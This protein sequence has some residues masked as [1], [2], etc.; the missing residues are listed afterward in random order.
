M[1]RRLQK[2]AQN[3][4]QQKGS[5]LI[6]KRLM[7]IGIIIFT[8]AIPSAIGPVFLGLVRDDIHAHSFVGDTGLQVITICGVVTALLGLYLFFLGKRMSHSPDS[9]LP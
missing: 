2:N 3:K 7:T 4:I 1:D 5:P 6:K 8:A 9:R